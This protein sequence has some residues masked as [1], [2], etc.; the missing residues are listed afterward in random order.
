MTVISALLPKA[1]SGFTSISLDE[2]SNRYVKGV[3]ISSVPSIRAKLIS[4]LM[5][6][7][8]AMISRFSDTAFILG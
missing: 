3:E 5:A 7:T 2:I 1:D 8:V 6:A 4:E